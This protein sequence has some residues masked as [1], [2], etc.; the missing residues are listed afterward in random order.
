MK[1]SL[2][3]CEVVVIGVGESAIR[4]TMTPRGVARLEF[5]SRSAAEEG[6]SCSREPSNRLASEVADQLTAYFEGKRR[7]L[8]VPVDLSACSPF[9]RRVLEACA[10]VP[11]GQVISY[12]ELALRVGQPNAARAVGRAL[13]RNPVPILVPCHRIV[14][15]DGGLGGFTAGLEW[16][17]RLLRLEGVKI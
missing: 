6:S 17:R 4:L 9:Q 10:Q 15:A 2:P 14:R 11:A 1:D 3:N 13:A 8:D 12:G 5:V 16:K 7:H